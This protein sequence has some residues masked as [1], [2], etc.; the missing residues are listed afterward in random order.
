[1]MKDIAQITKT[2]LEIE[3][4]I[5]QRWN[6]GDCTGFLEAYRDDVTYIDP[7]TEQCLVGREAVKKHFDKTFRGIIVVQSDCFNE[8]VTIN[9]SQ[10]IAVLTYN[11][12]N[13]FVDSHGVRQ[14]VPLWNCTEVYRLERG[15]WN[16]FHNHWS[17][18]RHPSVI[19]NLSA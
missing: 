1:M 19:Q 8:R 17:F 13:Y 7:L 5:N 10:D 15:K 16:I 18:A 3:H 12:Q 4:S 9:E 11:L 14:T 6:A 2:I